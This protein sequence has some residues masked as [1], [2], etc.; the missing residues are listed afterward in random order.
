MLGV[1]VTRPPERP[2]PLPATRYWM[3]LLLLLLEA[4]VLLLLLPPVLSP[5]LMEEVSPCLNTGL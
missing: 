2:S 1:M 4:P 3:V 5:G